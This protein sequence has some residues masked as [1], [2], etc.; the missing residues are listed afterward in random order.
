MLLELLYEA[1]CATGWSKSDNP[2]ALEVSHDRCSHNKWET[3]DTVLPCRVVSLSSGLSKAHVFFLFLALEQVFAKVNRGRLKSSICT[4]VGVDERL[5]DAWIV[6]CWEGL[7]LCVG[8]NDDGPISG[9]VKDDV[10]FSELGADVERSVVVYIVAVV[11][12]HIII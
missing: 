6:V 9:C 4:S 1:V 2:V 11:Q 12:C 3:G 7:A 8:T 5:T 10:V